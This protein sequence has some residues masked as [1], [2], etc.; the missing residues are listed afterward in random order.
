MMNNH[1]SVEFKPSALKELKKLDKNSQNRIFHF[2]D[3]VKANSSPRVLGKPLKGEWS[4]FWS[5]RVGQYRMVAHLKDKVMM[6]TIVKFDHR[7]DV[8]KGH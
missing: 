2:I 8:Y 3:T 5:F 1:W 4:G 6:I 7:K